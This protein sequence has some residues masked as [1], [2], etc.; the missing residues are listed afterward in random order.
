LVGAELVKRAVA[1]SGGV[2]HAQV[3]N[4]KHGDTRLRLGHAG[5]ASGEGRSKSDFFQSILLK[6]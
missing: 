2:G 6:R 1:R 4:A 5:E 3:H